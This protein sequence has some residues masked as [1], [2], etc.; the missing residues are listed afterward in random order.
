MSIE[1][2]LLLKDKQLVLVLLSE[3]LLLTTYYYP[4]VGWLLL[5]LQKLGK[6]VY[7]EGLAA[8]MNLS[9]VKYAAVIILSFSILLSL[10][11][12]NWIPWLIAT[13]LLIK[14]SSAGGLHHA[15]MAAMQY[16]K[17]MRS[18]MIQMSSDLYKKMQNPNIFLLWECYSYL[19]MLTLFGFCSIGSFVLEHVVACRIFPSSYSTS[20][21]FF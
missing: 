5:V 6:N 8:K 21:E 7:L 20:L 15:G 9:M 4:L 14:T 17:L 19:R 11:E 3:L 10:A 16:N 12:C 2:G 13:M 18:Q 1:W